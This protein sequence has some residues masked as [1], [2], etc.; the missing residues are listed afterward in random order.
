M[1]EGYKP[2][3][4]AYVSYSQAYSLSLLMRVRF[5]QSLLVLKLV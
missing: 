5:F 1:Y 3:A 4:E 2:Q